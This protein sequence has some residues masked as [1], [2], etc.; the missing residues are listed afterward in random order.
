MLHC[1]RPER[2]GQLRGIPA[3]TPALILFAYLR[4]FTVATIDAAE[5]AAEFAAIL[6]SDNA[7]DTTTALNPFDRIELER[8]ALLTVPLGQKLAQL[9]AEHPNATYE[10]FVKCI[11]REIARCL[12][13]PAIVALG[14]ASAYN[15]SS[16]KADIVTFFRQIDT[17]RSLMYEPIL[18]RIFHEWF[19]EAVLIDNFLPAIVASNFNDF[20]WRWMWPENKAIDRQKEAAGVAQELANMTTSLSIEL[21]AKNISWEDHLKQVARERSMMAELGLT[22]AT[23]PTTP[24]TNAPD[25]EDVPDQEDA[26]NSVPN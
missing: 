2:P 6:Y 17:D 23:P 20:E 3:L 14:D 13:V 26:V 18:D 9:K 25:P 11:L 7:P 4:R 24:T 10:Q 16:A 21:S 22:V 12:G 1:F 19:D 5:T 8:G 15:F